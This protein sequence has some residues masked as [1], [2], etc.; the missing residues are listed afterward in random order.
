MQFPG[1]AMTVD[2]HSFVLLP[3]PQVQTFISCTLS[4]IPW[5]NMPLS[6]S[7]RLGASSCHLWPLQSYPAFKIQ[8][9][10][11]TSPFLI[12][13]SERDLSLPQTPTPSLAPSHFVC[14]LPRS[15]TITLCL[16][17]SFH[18]LEN[19]CPLI[20]NL[21]S[22]VSDLFLSVSLPVHNYIELDCV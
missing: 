3:T 1:I 12:L 14:N 4:F 7:Q 18:A 13:E 5:P 16:S 20:N 2:R 10:L 11:V 15:M 21:N 17:H 9:D 6:C 8:P 19:I 22:R